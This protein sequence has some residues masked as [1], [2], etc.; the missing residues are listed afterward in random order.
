MRRQARRQ[1]LDAPA[2]ESQ[3][4][5]DHVLS[6]KEHAS[7]Q[8]VFFRFALGRIGFASARDVLS[9]ENASHEP[10]HVVERA[11]A[12]FNA[13]LRVFVSSHTSAS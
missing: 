5:Q 6:L 12:P 3:S 9:R 7:R 1:R 4:N 10:Q 2:C 11:A 8:R 13:G